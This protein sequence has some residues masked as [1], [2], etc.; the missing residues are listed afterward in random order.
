MDI[1]TREALVQHLEKFAMCATNKITLPKCAKCSN[2]PVVGLK[3]ATELNLVKRL[4]T[5]GCRGD[6]DPQP[7]ILKRYR[8]QF[9]GIGT[10][11]GEYEMNIDASVTPVVHPPRRIPYILRDK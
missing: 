7:E 10:L 5:V 11:P 9:S 3:T 8:G 4:F 2:P 6:G 1:I